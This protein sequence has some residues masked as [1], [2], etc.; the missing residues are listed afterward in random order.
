MVFLIVPP[1][2]GEADGGRGPPVTE[3]G[4]DF[5]GAGESHEDEETLQ[6]VQN[7]ERVPEGLQIDEPSGLVAMS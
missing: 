3:A 6:R 1:A 4:H 5:F 2:V 7:H